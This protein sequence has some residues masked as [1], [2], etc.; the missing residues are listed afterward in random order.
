MSLQFDSTELL[1]P[2][3]HRIKGYVNYYFTFD[4]RLFNKKTN[5][6]SKKVVRGYSIGFNLNGRFYTESNL[7]EMIIKTK[8]HQNESDRLIDK[9]NNIY[10]FTNFDVLV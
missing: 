4:N 7:E 1:H 10:D 9:I 3:K 2:P 6:F 8:K 5:R